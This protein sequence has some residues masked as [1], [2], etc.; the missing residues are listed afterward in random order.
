MSCEGVPTLG[1][2]PFVGDSVDICARI[3]TINTIGDPAYTEENSLA[4]CCTTTPPPLPLGFTLSQTCSGLDITLVADNVVG[5]T[6]PY[7]FST[8][9]F[10]D[11]NGALDNTTWTT[12]LTSRNYF[13]GNAPGTYW[14]SIKDS[15][16]LIIVEEIN[17][18]CFN[19]E[20]ATRYAAYVSNATGIIMDEMCSNSLTPVWIATRVPN[21]ADIGDVVF[22]TPISGGS[23]RYN[24]YNNAN[25]LSQ[26]RRFNTGSMFNTSNCS[27]VFIPPDCVV[28]TSD[29]IRIGSDGEIL[30]LGCCMPC[31]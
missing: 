4:D 12:E 27:S 26:Y 15:L 5:G 11:I 7:Q 6:G 17:A 28:P 8:T 22:T 1:E 30:E 20:T 3:N 25:T 29:V 10:P 9:T 21:F 14:V 19:P 2:L 18:D 31:S 13:L 24:G 16:G 23:I